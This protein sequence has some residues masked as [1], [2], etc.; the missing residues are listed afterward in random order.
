MSQSQRRRT[1]DTGWLSR[2]WL[3]L[4]PVKS[5]DADILWRNSRVQP[6]PLSERYFNMF[7]ISLIRRGSFPT[8]P[9]SRRL[10]RRRFSC[11]SVLQTATSVHVPPS[12]SM[13]PSAP[14]PPTISGIPTHTPQPVVETP[15]DT[16]TRRHNPARQPP[17]NPNSLNSTTTQL[18][19]SNST[20][21]Q[22]QLDSGSTP[23]RLQLDSNPTST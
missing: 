1:A 21:A 9:S 6:F 3:T 15:A 10:L 8:S 22:L 11:G 7:K 4:F 20:P 19:P 2:G 14:L 23:T 17:H 12:G 18:Q 13:R 16:S 5:S